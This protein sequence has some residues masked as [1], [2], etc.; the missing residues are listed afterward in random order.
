MHCLCAVHIILSTVVSF[1]RSLH[2]G[3]NSKT[4]HWT[5]LHASMISSLT[6]SLQQLLPNGYITLYKTSREA[7]AASME[8]SVHFTIKILSST[9]TDCYGYALRTYRAKV[10]RPQKFGRAKL[11]KRL[12]LLAFCLALP[13]TARMGW[14]IFPLWAKL[15][16]TL[17]SL[18]YQET[19][20]T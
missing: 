5:T 6:M 16:T 12:L 4:P 8:K 2:K 17:M 19:C 15:G 9:D 1:C 7:A 20:E 10:S 3:L 13:T 11:N 14:A 18:H